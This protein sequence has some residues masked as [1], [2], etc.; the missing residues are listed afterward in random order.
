MTDAEAFEAYYRRLLLFVARALAVPG[1][2]VVSIF[3]QL[4]YLAEQLFWH[5]LY[6]AESLKLVQ[7]IAAYRDFLFVICFGDLN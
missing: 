2:V 4:Q 3:V 7:E 6:L 5:A 1:Q